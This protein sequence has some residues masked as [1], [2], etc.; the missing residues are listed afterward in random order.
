MKAIVYDRFGPPEVLQL[1]D[2]PCPA[3]GP[4][5]VLVRVHALP[6]GPGDVKLRAGTLGD[7]FTV[8][9]PKVPGRYASGVV[10]A[11]GAGVAW[12]GTGTEV[13]LA[14]LHD[15]AGTA[16]EHVLTT[17]SRLAA[18]PA[19]FSHVEAAAFVQGAVSAWSCLIETADLQPGERLLVHGGAGAVG[20]TAIELGRH[21]GAHV[22]AT[23]RSSDT[24][25]V[26]A[27]GADHVA[28]FDRPGEVERETGQDVVLDVIGGAVHARSHGLL[29]PGG[30]LVYLHALP[31]V[32]PPEPRDVRVRNARV[33]ASAT[34]L[35]RV[36]RLA[37]RNVLRPRIA[38][39]LG[40]EHAAKAHTIVESGA[41][42]RG[43][44][45]LQ[46]R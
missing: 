25:H 39:V 34:V 37:E 43:R 24:D 19:A 26:S 42:K 16:A 28:A 46:V 21:L 31:L 5:E 13:V 7:F 17:P 45:V 12:P 44:V 35:D 9:F 32:Q 3:P 22:T 2:L 40:L 41:G 4:G 6:V 29:R 8:R 30:R 20:S 18:K 14:S 15:D 1:R 33:D 36:S 23:C 27:L 10:E 11:V 38:A